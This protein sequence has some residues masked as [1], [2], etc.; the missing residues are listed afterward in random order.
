MGDRKISVKSKKIIKYGYMLIALV[1]CFLTLKQFP[2]QITR[3]IRF[4]CYALCLLSLYGRESVPD[5]LGVIFDSFWKK[6]LLVVLEIYA[7]LSATGMYFL[8]TTFTYE[9][10]YVWFLYFIMSFCWVCPII[11]YFIACFIRWSKKTAFSDHKARL[12]TR[13][14]LMGIMMIPCLLFLIAFNPAIT[15]P[16]SETCL[17]MAA[18]LW[19]P[20]SSILNWHPPFYALVLALLLKICASVSFIIV[21]Q[22]VCFAAVFVDGILFL[23][24]CGYSKKVLGIIYIF[25]AFGISNLIQL[26]TLWKDIPYMISLMWLTLLLMKFVIRH[27]M[28]KNNP[29]WY[30]QLVI[31]VIFTCFFR[32]NGILPALA[33]VVIFPIAAKF[34]KKAM[35]SSIACILLIVLIT[36]PL[37]KSMNVKSVPHL[38]F[39]SLANDIMNSYYEGKD[40]S[41]EAM[42]IINKVTNNNPDGWGYFPYVVNYNP[43]EPQGYSTAEFLM[44]YCENFLRNPKETF[45]AA[46]ARNS[47]IWSI[48]RPYDE[49][50]SCVNNLSECNGLALYPARRPNS[51]T[52]IL[53]DLCNRLT[54]NRIIYLFIWRTGIYNLL[55]LIMIVSTFCAHREQKLFYMMPY[56]PIAANLLALFISSGWSDYRYYWPSMSISLLLLCYFLFTLRSGFA[57]N[58]VRTELRGESQ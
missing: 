52:Q 46:A 22:Q 23:Y 6:I 47:A 11:Q 42:E 10:E 57:D 51:L 2:W 44:I 50:A 28:Y 13:W 14:I 45:M 20:D 15:T 7:V 1:C 4:I 55:I 58:C 9:T 25:I 34:S 43:D 53:T 36:G 35:L 5:E 33:V 17:S 24:Q 19:Q 12:S 16:D 27:D 30:I 29:G 31:A 39:V 40:V 8:K 32:Q 49:A 56:A 48:A 3:K 38:K 54:E 21:M 41:E 37:Y 18:S 26:T